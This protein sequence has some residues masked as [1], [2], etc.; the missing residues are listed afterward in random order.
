MRY[1]CYRL[2]VLAAALTLLCPIGTIG[3]GQAEDTVPQRLKEVVVT[4]TRTPVPVE[5]SASA[6][7]IIDA[8]AIEA[9]QAKTVLE[10]LRDVL[11]LDVRQSGGLGGQT[12]VFMRGGNSSH[13]L[14]MIDGCKSIARPMARSIFP[15]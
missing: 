6:V 8:E 2:P 3:I 4:A 15:I 14:V 13:T 11:G 5:Q 7:T 9:K 1:L 12:S 10:V